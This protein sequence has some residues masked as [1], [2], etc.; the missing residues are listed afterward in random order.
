[1]ADRSDGPGD[2]GSTPASK[3]G[4]PALEALCR[5]LDGRTAVVLSGAGCSTESGIP[6]YRGEGRRRRTRSPIL[7]QEFMADPGARARY[8]LRSTAG[9]PRFRAARPNPGHRAVARLE[10]VGAVR[11]VITQNVDG[12]HQGG[13]SRR[14][15]E[16]HGSLDRVRCMA[17]SGVEDRGALQ[18]RLL[19]L[20][21]DL[22]P[23]STVP[24]PDGD[25]HVDPELHRPFQV[26][27]C[28]TC[29]GILKP[30]V[31]FFGENVPR[32]RLEQAWSLYEEGD[33]LLVL[34]SSLAVFSGRRF[35]LRAAKD[36]RPV[37]IVNQGPTRGDHVA[38][39]RV[40]GR[41]GAVLPRLAR[42]LAHG[43][44]LPPL[45]CGA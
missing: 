11:G 21:P 37:A 3:Q 41:L 39:V 16:L 42:R 33:V 25:A 7:F 14:V 15:L 6:D 31:V 4:E 40:E 26:P 38:R 22:E 44:S 19:E 29:G 28:R 24:A 45:A 18:E 32:D 34:G 36:G 12:L 35:I 8:W 30:D 17:C 5:I 20:N 1:M 9:W 43:S 10:E 2:A 27:G 13:G 23:A